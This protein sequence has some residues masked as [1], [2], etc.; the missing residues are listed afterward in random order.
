MR[1][2]VACE[3]DQKL[4]YIAVSHIS[5]VNVYNNTYM[6]LYLQ[7]LVPLLRIYNNTRVT[8]PLHIV[9]KY[10]VSKNLALHCYRVAN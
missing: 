2:Y 1:Y 10:K 4:H 9:Y 5:V 7:K 3:Y 8:R 6:I